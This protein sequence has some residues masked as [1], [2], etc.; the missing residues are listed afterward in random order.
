[1]A[2]VCEFVAQRQG[3]ESV[4]SCLLERAKRVENLG[5]D[6]IGERCCRVCFLGL[7]EPLDEVLDVLGF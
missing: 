6:D 1:M 4:G 2:I 5:C 3:P 7:I